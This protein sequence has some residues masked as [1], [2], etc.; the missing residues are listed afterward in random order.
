MDGE[1]EGCGQLGEVI[2]LI[3]P[4]DIIQFLGILRGQRLAVPQDLA[5][6]DVFGLYGRRNATQVHVRGFPM[7][8]LRAMVDHCLV[9]EGDGPGGPD[10][11]DGEETDAGR[12][13]AAQ[14]P[15]L[16]RPIGIQMVMAIFCNI[17]RSQVL[18]YPWG[19][20]QVA[21]TPPHTP[22]PPN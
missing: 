5:D 11:F 4:A 9:V 6:S 3:V 15:T 7:G 1:Q 18:V 10:L 22:A 20:P 17:G 13:L 8:F 14:Q 2:H 12:L 21:D 19:F 16:S